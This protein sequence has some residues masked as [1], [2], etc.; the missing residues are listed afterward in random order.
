MQINKKTAC[1]FFTDSANL[2]TYEVEII[3]YL[4][5]ESLNNQD[6]KKGF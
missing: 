4:R 1:A 5:Q 2:Q 6:C 3:S